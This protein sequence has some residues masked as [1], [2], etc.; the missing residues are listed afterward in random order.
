MTIEERWEYFTRDWL[1]WQRF[2]GGNPSYCL[3]AVAMAN[4]DKHRHAYDT[5]I[6]LARYWIGQIEASETAIS[7]AAYRATLIEAAG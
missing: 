1:C 5:Y 7:R 4:A 3:L 6:D 2:A